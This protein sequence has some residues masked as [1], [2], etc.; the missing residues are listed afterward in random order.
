MKPDVV[1]A[2]YE[3][4][5]LM[6]VVVDWMVDDIDDN[7]PTAFPST[8]RD[9]LRVIEAHGTGGIPWPDDFTFNDPDLATSVCFIRSYAYRGR[10]ETSTDQLLIDGE[11]DEC[12][13]EER[14]RSAVARF[15]DEAG[16]G[17]I[18]A[19]TADSGPGFNWGDAMLS[20]PYDWWSTEGIDFYLDGRTS[21]TPDVSV[22]VDAD[23]VLIPNGLWESL[24]SEHGVDG[25]GKGGVA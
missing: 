19:A 25:G 4:D 3:Y 2:A 11:L 12:E 15:F 20:I 7:G 18:L 16:D 23:E 14:I 1:L 6:T 9:V 22:L 5:H 13:A 10:T 21:D 8:A 17:E 24:T